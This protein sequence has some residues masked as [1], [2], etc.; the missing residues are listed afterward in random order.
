MRLSVTSLL[1][2][3]AAAC[4]S[5]TEPPLH[6]VIDSTAT[7]IALRV[8]DTVRVIMVATNISNGPIHVGPRSCNGDEFQLV[9]TR[10]RV[11]Q[12]VVRFPFPCAVVAPRLLN[13]GEQIRI[14]G[15]TDGLVIT[16]RVAAIPVQIPPGLYA[17]R[18]TVHPADADVSAIS[19]DV[20]PRVLLFRKR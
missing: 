6:L 3:I 9:D 16:E 19:I 11:F 1:L 2:A 8:G 14:D 15:R 4:S 5:T 13:P 18:S 20:R 10:G 17:V 12:P 7:D